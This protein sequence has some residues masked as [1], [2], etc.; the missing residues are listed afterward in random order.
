MSHHTRGRKAEPVPVAE[1]VRA[2]PQPPKAMGAE[3]RKEWRRV[4]PVLV[5]RRVLSE[6]DI[7]AVERFCE[8]S[9]D[10]VIA[11][12]AIAAD[13]AYTPNRFGELKRHPAFA[14]LREATAEARRWAAELGLSPASR[15]RVEIG[16]DDS[17]DSL[18]DY[19]SGAD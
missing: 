19:E 14:T 15:S 18:M 9:G 6:A 12:T 16:E 11:R 3:A 5:E 2:V 8:A 13:G 10:I 17:A 7:H 1:P 4:M